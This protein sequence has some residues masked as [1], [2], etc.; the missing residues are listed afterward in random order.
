MHCCQG[1]F[2]FCTCCVARLVLVLRRTCLVPNVLR[3][4]IQDNR[5]D[6]STSHSTCLRISR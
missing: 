3:A 2:N 4:I 5:A 1:A 6:D